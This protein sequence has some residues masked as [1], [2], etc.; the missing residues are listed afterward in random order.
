MIKISACLVIVNE[1]AAI[2]DCLESIKECVDEIIVVHDGQCLDKT[3][4]IC[5]EYTNKIFVQNFVGNA[6]PH[7]PFSYQKAQGEWIFQI[8]ADERLSP[9]LQKKLRCLSGDKTIDAYEFLWP[10]PG[11]SKKDKQKG[12]YKR[13]FFRKKRISFIG[14]PHYIVKVK[15]Q[16]KKVELILEHRP[17][18]EK[19][20]W[21]IFR[22]KWL[23]W[24]RLQASFYN[25][26]FN[27]ISKYNYNINDWPIK[28]KIKIIFSIVYLP[29]D[30]LFTGI[31]ELSKIS[32]WLDI[33]EFQ[34]VLM[35]S[36]YRAFLDW[37]IFIGKFKKKS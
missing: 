19:I 21:K 30:F 5:K 22:N 29:F 33:Y 2:R 4:D 17:K 10:R 7:R 16:V 36:L 15:G 11:M 9:E 6:E 8:D 34:L 25:K 18:Y 12:N 23:K 26:D 35:K 31:K 14:I 28:T 1:E 20:S 24:A 13:C 27:L 32:S 37:Y 3:L